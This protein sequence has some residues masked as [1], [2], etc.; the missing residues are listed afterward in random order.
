MMWAELLSAAPQLTSDQPVR[1][2]LP[3]IQTQVKVE[4]RAV[5]TDELERRERFLSV[6]IQNLFTA[7]LR[8]GW[9]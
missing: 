5:R 3:G 6:C 7:C 1:F 9:G 4:G 8:Q 2:T